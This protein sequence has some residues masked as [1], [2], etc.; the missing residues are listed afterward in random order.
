ME[1][2]GEGLKEL[3]T[4]DGNHIEGP[5]VSTNLDLWELPETKS[6]TR[7]HTWANQRP[8]EHIEDCLVWH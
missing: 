2:L 3:K 6:P 8:L 5:A 7:E 4:D 1:E